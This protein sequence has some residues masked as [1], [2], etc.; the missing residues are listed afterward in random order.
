MGWRLAAG[1]GTDASVAP[2]QLYGHML[3]QRKR[4]LAVGKAKTQ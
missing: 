3:H 2:L 4:A 1:R